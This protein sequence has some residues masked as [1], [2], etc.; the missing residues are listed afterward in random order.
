MFIKHTNYNIQYDVTG[1]IGKRYRRQDE[2][3]TPFCIT[4]DFDSLEDKKVTVRHRDSMA[5]E[6]IAVDNLISYIDDQMKK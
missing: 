5:Q 3:G 2:I 6:R 1:S 4:I